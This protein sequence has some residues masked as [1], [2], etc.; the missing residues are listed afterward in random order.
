M[1]K[2]LILGALVIIV[3]LVAG[4][5]VAI[6]MQPN[7][8]RVARS[9]TINAPSERVFAQVNDFRKWEAWSPWAKIDPAMKVTY[10]GPP[11]GVG[12]TYAWVGND[13]VGEG[14]MTI[15]ESHPSSH[16]KIDLEFIKPFA[17]LADTEFILKPNGDKTDVEWS[18]AGKHN[19]ISKA[20]CL[21]VSMDKMIGPDFE[22][23]V[24]QL[25]TAAETAAN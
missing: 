8:Y 21:V 23:G 6:A 22:K 9:T 2:K 15:N 25:K 24:N 12:A 13:E 19:V 17:S 1:L 10:G 7:E 16:I 5:A 20:M 3:L 11:S 14:R 4:L 18:I